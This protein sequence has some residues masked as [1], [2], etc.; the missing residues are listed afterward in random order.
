MN[1]VSLMGMCTKTDWGGV[2]GACWI[3]GKVSL[4]SHV[5]GDIKPAFQT[6]RE[7]SQIE[8]CSNMKA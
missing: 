8:S 2:G 5:N 1:S 3:P 4:A 7:K 6:E